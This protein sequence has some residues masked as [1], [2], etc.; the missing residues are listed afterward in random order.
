MPSRTGHPH[1]V[2]WH[3]PGDG[4]RDVPVSHSAPLAHSATHQATT[5]LAGVEVCRG[6]AAVM[7]VFYH[8]A[9]HLEKAHGPTWL[10]GLW[11]FGHAGVDLFFVISGFNILAVHL[12]DI[13]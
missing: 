1:P 5:R 9:R 8:V 3:R 11:Q 4:N 2:G 7:V 6:A 10:M 13:G 12:D